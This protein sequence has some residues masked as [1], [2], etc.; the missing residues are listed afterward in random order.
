MTSMAAIDSNTQP[1]HVLL[2][3]P[4]KAV[5]SA[6]CKAKSQSDFPLRLSLTRFQ[7]IL[8]V[9]TGTGTW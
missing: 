4:S 7:R 3:A 2:D 9:G 1:S 8:D 6:N 5:S